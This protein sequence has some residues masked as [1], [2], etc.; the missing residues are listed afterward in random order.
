MGLQWNMQASK[1]KKNFKYFLKVNKELNKFYKGPLPNEDC[2]IVN[3]D[4]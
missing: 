4:A 3:D 1:A 2:K